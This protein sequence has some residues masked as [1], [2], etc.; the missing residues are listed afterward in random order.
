MDRIEYFADLGVNAVMPLPFQEY[1]GENSLGYNGT[2]L[3]S[4]EMDYAVRGR[5]PPYLARVNRLLAAKGFAPLAAAQ[6]TGQINQFKA[7]IDLCHLYGIAVITDVVYNHAGGGFDDQSMWFFDRQPRTTDN[8]SLY[9]TDQDHAGGRVFAFWK[10]EVRQFLIDN[11]K[12]LLQEYHVDGLR[13]DQVTVIDENGGW[14]FAQDLTNTLRYVKPAA[15]QIAEYWGNE[16]WKGIATPPHGMGFDIGYSDALRDT[17]REVI[18]ATTG[19]RD[20]RVESRPAARGALPHLPGRCALDRLP[21]HREPRP[22]RRQSHRPRP[23]AAHR[24]TRRS[25]QRA[26]LVCAQPR[27]G[28]DG[29]SADRAGR[30]DDLHGPG[31]PRGQV[32]DRL[33]ES[34]GAADLVGRSRGQGQAH[35]RPAPLHA[36][37][38]VA[39]AKTSGAARRRHERLPRQQRQPRHRLPSLAAGR[40]AAMWSWSRA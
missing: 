17:L 9:F 25:D 36:R 6:L 11:G 2:D 40:R 32:L 14:Y 18:A 33:A 7:F 27:Q 1:Q 34:A 21:M 24:R 10:Q 31:V 15:V 28:G 19:G 22:A 13:Y 23:S 39:A 30:P 35:V 38:H 8:N 5:A 3:F 26:L 29:P 4:P 12:S 16:R 20:A 37:P